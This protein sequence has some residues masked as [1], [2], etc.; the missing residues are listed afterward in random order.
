MVVL[1]QRID[2]LTKGKSKKEKIDKGKSEKGLIAGS[3]DWDK[4][5]VSLEDEGTTRLKAFMAIA[6]DEPSVGKADARNLFPPLPKLTGA[7]PSSASKSLISLSDLTANMK[8]T[9][10]KHPAV[11]NSRPDKNALP[12]TEQLLLTLKEEVKG[13]KVV[14]EDDSSGD[15]EGYV[16]INC[17]GITFTRV[18]YVNGLKHNLISISQLCDAN[19]KV[20]FTKTQETIFNQNDEVVLIALRRRDVYVIDMSSFNKEINACI[21]A[22]ASLRK[23]SDAADCIMSFIRKMENLNEVRVKE[24]RSDN[25]TE[26]RNHKLEEFCNEK[27][28]TMLNNAKL[29]KQ[30]L[31]EAV[32]TACYTQNRSIIVKR[33]GKTAYDVFRGRSPNISYFHVF[34]CPI[35]IHNHKDHLGKFDEKAD[36]G[37]F[38]GY[39][40]V[41]KAFRVFNIKRQEMEEI[42]HVTFSEDDEVISQT[43]T[44]GDAIN[45]NENRS[46]PDDEFIKP[47][48]KN[49]QCSVNIEYFPYVYAY[50]NITSSVL[51]TLQNSVTSK[52]PL[53][54]TIADGPPADHEPAYVESA[55]ILE[56]VKPQDNVISESISNDQ[57]ALVISPSAKVILQNHVLQDRWSR[58][59]HIELVNIIGELLVGITTRSRNRDSDVASAHECLYANFISEIKPKKLIEALDEEG[60]VIA[61]QAELDQFK[62]NKPVWVL[63]VFPDHVCKLDKALYGMKQALRAWYQANPKESHFVVVRY[64]KGTLNLGLWYPKGSG[65]DLK[66]YSD[67]DYTGCNLD[68]KSTSGGCQILRGKIVCWSAKKQSSVAMSSTDAEYVAAAG[69]YAQVLWIKIQ[70]ADYDVLYDKVPIFCDNTSAISI[71][72]NPVLHSRTKHIDIGYH[73]I[74]DHILKGAIELYFIPTE[75]QL[76]DIFTK[77]LAE[78]SFARLVAEL[79]VNDATKDI[80]FSLSLFENQLLFT[81]FDFLT[82]IGLT[83]SKTAV[84]LPPKGTVRAGL[85]TLRLTDK[86]KPSLTSTELVD[87]SPL[88]VKYYSPIWKIFMPY[89]VKCLGGMRGSHDH[90]NLSQQT[91]AYCLTFGLEI[92]IGEIIFND[93]IQMLQNRKKN[94]ELNTPSASK[95]SL[96]SHMMKV[97]KLSK[98]PEESLILPFVEVNAEESADKSQSRTNVQ[99]LS[100]PK[101]PTAKK[102]KKKKIPS[103]TKP[104]VSNVSRE[105]NPSSTTTHLHETKEFMATTIPIQNVD[106]DD[107]HDNEVSHSA[108]TSQEDIAS[109]A[110][111]SLLDHLDHICEEVSSLHSRHGNMESSIV[112]MLSDEI[113]SYLLAMIT[114]ALTKQLPGILSATL[115]DCFPMI[116]K[117]SLQTHILASNKFVTLQRELSK[118]IKSE[119]AKKVQVVGLEGFRK[120]LQ[121]Q[122]KKISK[123]SSSFQD[124]QTKLQD[125][126]DL[127]ELADLVDLNIEQDSK[128]DDNDLDK[129]PLSKRFKIMHPILSKPQPSVKQFTD[130]LFRTTSSKFSPTPPREPTPL[131]DESKGKGI[132]VEEP[133]KNI[134]PFMEQGGSVLKMPKLKSFITPEG[135]LFQEEFYNQIKEMKRLATLKEQ[136]KKLEEELKELLNQLPLR[137]KL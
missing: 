20:L 48:P 27:A 78:P 67:L 46:F 109:A 18:A 116:V 91:I 121:S 69:C 33:Y 36:D 28:R 104:K 58:E 98:E 51:P 2:D 97:A 85:V 92:N 59:K 82:T 126:K 117:E 108:H 120:E 76:A 34:R 35:H 100:Q 41:A 21:L 23:K 75:L 40:L 73:F 8:R 110:R 71:S 49:T 65:F 81:R 79:E 7:D 62:R 56:S 119:V 10:S 5:S 61:M 37:F 103:S 24:L 39:S 54:F 11:Q 88:K 22:K 63:R 84:P 42:V 105:M 125:I 106:S 132:V 57:P 14:F 89:I 137:L 30:F 130:Q 60:W 44:K 133:P 47:R 74:R 68:R 94:K 52:E 83:Y 72:N 86:D 127:L 26:F 1:T 122:T 9:E 96:T 38:L 43:N 13:P 3:F 80:S 124:M 101:A 87:S 135:N 123:Y 131:R 12:S 17:N 64:L 134:I 115:K 70:L 29:P 114:N 45:F 50:E 6:E 90:M 118:V 16:L 112:Q 136:E 99:P 113:K 32:N 4:I 102:P 77:P 93:L 55:E 129:Q 66:A 25:E 31:G 53:E 111:L 128:D 95:V 107:T 19:V 15:S